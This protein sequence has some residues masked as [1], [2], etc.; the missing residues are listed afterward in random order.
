MSK[1]KELP[2]NT[3]QDAELVLNLGTGM[4]HFTITGDPEILQPMADEAMAYDRRH[5]V[6]KPAVSHVEAPKT[7]SSPQPEYLS[8]AD[9]DER[10]A[11]RRALKAFGHDIVTLGRT[12]LYRQFKE[13]LH[14]EQDA[15]VMMEL[16]IV[17]AVHCRLHERV[18]AKAR[19]VR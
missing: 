3:E 2:I 7:V 1:T 10:T 5:P 8:L 6:G 12:R 15:K 14:A 17:D 4:E 11:A 16:G 13:K 9:L 18:V 19:G